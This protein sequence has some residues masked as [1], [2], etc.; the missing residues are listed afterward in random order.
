M[1]VIRISKKNILHNYS[2]LQSL[3]EGTAMFPVLKSNAYGHGLEQVVRILNRTDAEYLVVDSYPEYIIA[4][5]YSSK[6]ILLLGET[7]DENYKYFD[8]K[9]TTFCV[10][11]LS[12]LEY[13]ADRGKELNIHLFVNTWMNR[14][15]IDESQLSDVLDLLEKN[16]QVH[17]TGVMSHL[18]S[19]DEVYYDQID[20]Q[21]QQFKKLYME[22][23]NHGHTPI[24][25][26]IGNTAWMMKI[27]EDFFNAYR[28]GIGLF[29]YN[30]LK[31]EDKAFL[32]GKK[33][34]PVMT[35]TSRVV[36]LHD[37]WP[38]DG[39]SYNH[40]W[41]AG[42]KEHVAVIPFGYA[43]WLSRSAS[44]RIM[45]RCGRKYFQQIGNICMNL[46]VCKVDEGTALGEE[47]EIVSMD[48]SAKNTM[49]VLAQESGT[50]V[51][52]TLARLDKWIRREVE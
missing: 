23:I 46:C 32:L 45:F 9:R 33:L 43:E 4:K 17:V 1:N 24:R 31:S 2:V 3:Q 51:Y 48:S 22:I 16:S 7:L 39:V 5:K 49:Y 6:P 35:I 30:P 21:I 15:G 18:H 40:T 14:E 41:K 47:I 29:G 19:A 34:K 8:L 50:I 42:E 27:T 28:P 38:G 12:T 11:N 25:R 37:V 26:H 10:Y 52:E 13:L 44:S 20:A 36:G